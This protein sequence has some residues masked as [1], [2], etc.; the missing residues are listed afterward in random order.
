[1]RE[2]DNFYEDKL[3][4]RLSF[5]QHFYSRPAEANDEKSLYTYNMQK[6]I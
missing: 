5:G 4:N 6:H 2:P 1:M 3:R